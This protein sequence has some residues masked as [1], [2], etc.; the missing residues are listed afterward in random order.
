MV[1]FARK[2]LQTPN[3]ASIITFWLAPYK[4]CNNNKKKCFYKINWNGTHNCYYTTERNHCNP[5]SLVIHTHMSRPRVISV[6]TCTRTHTRTESER[7]LPAPLRVWGWCL[8]STTRT[9]SILIALT[10]RTAST[11][12]RPLLHYVS[13]L[14][15]SIPHSFSPLLFSLVTVWV[16]Q[17]ASTSSLLHSGCTQMLAR[18]DTHTHTYAQASKCPFYTC[19]Y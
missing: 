4:L 12:T 19:C 5:N 2:W 17:S 8:S 9:I 3:I 14:P 15:P 7:A 1:L 13:S 11:H 6:L 10:P 16:S 18:I